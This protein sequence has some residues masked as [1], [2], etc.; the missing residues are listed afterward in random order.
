[1][2]PCCLIRR[3]K[4]TIWQ[5]TIEDVL[6]ILPET[7]KER[8]RYGQWVKRE[9]CIYD[10]FTEKMIIKPDDLPEMEYYTG[11]QDFGLNIAGGKGRI[12]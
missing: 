7:Q 10:R 9:G 5:K 3:I 6:E 2:Y 1:M 11:G 8:F 12:L 4:D